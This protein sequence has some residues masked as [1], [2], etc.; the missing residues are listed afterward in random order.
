MSARL[1]ARLSAPL[2]TLMRVL[3]RGALLAMALVAPARR[4]G[5][6]C[7]VVG[8][9]GGTCTQTRSISANVRNTVRLT[10]TPT[11]QTL[12]TPTDVDFG[13][14]FSVHAASTIEVKSN[15]TWQITV[16]SAAVTWTG[17]G[18]ARLTKPVADLLWGPTAD[19]GW[20]PMTAV[21]AVFATGAATN[22]TNAA[23][24]YRI[25]WF[26]ALDTPGTYAIAVTF[27]I[28]TT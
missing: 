18:G 5:A 7:T 27:T 15:D 23:L 14:G 20:T 26:F 3:A 22:S 24:F 16:R 10:V 12:G 28:S 9:A 1:S 17:S 4:A 25:N 19:G 2:R 6:Q 11:T 8:I 21:G 13:N